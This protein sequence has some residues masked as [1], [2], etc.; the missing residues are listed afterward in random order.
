MATTST[1][2]WDLVGQFLFS[3]RIV[4]GIYATLELT[5]IGM[6][7]GVVLGVVLA[8]LRLST[9]PLLRGA[10]WIY[11]WFFRGTP[12]LVQLLFWNFIA[13]LYPVIVIGI[14]GGPA[15]WHFSAN[16]LI[17]TF[18]AAILGLG[19]NEAAYMAEIIR[20]GLLSV[21]R[22]Q[23]LAAESIGMTD[24]LMMRRIVLP[25][26]LRVIVP[27]TGNQV[28]GMLKYTS[29]VSVVALPELLYSAQLIYTQT[30]QPIPLLLV[31]STWYLI[32]TTIL[33]IAQSYL[34]RHF[35][36]GFAGG[37]A[38][39]RTRRPKVQ[40]GARLIELESK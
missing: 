18:G 9:N 31:A 40:A 21:D 32:V 11:I 5:A 35:G 4:S 34:E 38:R 36:R 2:H 17:P 28:I 24:T 33:M 29:L 22:G 3:D 12:L 39:A 14:P 6:L 30:F 19:L 15:W 23:T 13:A 26:A 16:S 10:S 20:S 27:P 8:V 1:Y 37:Q 7:M 25:Q